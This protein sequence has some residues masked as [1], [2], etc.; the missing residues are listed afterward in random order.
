MGPGRDVRHGLGGLLSGGAPRAPRRGRRVLDGR[1]PRHGGGVPPLRPRDEVRDGRGA[2]A[3]PRRL[4]GRRS[5][6]ARPGL[7]R[8]PRHGRPGRPRRLPELVGVRPGCFLEATGRQGDDGQRPRH[9]PRHPRRLRGRRGVRGLG[10]Q[11]AADRGRVGVR[12]AGRPRRRGVRLGRRALPRR[13]GDGELLAG[14]VPVAE[15]Q[16]RRLRADLPGRELPAER[17]RALRHDGER[18]GVDGRL[19]RPAAS[20]RG[21]EPLLRPV[22]PARHLAG[23]ELQPGPA[24][25]AHPAPGDQGRLAPLRTELLPALPPGRPP[26]AD[27]RHV[28]VAPRL[29]LH[30]A[31]TLEGEGAT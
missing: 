21:G 10:G 31:T 1:A 24:R 26:A 14:R 6:P 29:P 27:D 18:L 17:L 13:E 20:R 11:G 19:V 9:A 25:G 12:R 15:P 22:Q 30:R 5:R 23:R 28:D 4:P 16:A 7:P 8:L 3:R 2:A